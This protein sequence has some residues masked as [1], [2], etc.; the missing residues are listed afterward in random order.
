MRKEDRRR[1]P[2]DVAFARGQQ[3]RHQVHQDK[4]R[5]R[6]ARRIKSDEGEWDC[7]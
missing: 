7:D 5:Q 3:P 1:N 2:I 6:R 4:R